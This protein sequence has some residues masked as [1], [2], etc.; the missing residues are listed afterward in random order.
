MNSNAA[1]GISFPLFFVSIVILYSIEWSC[2]IACA[3]Y[4]TTCGC[5]LIKYDLFICCSQVN[6][7][8]MDIS[9]HAN[10]CTM[11]TK[12]NKQWILSLFVI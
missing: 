5:C 2:F 4:S 10:A 11:H 1:G 12:T 3:L 6:K 9:K 8:T 7:Y